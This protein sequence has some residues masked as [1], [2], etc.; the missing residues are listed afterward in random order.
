MSTNPTRGT[1]AKRLIVALA[2]GAIAASL[3]MGALAAASTA[4]AS[5][6]PHEQLGLTTVVAD[7]H[8]YLGPPVFLAQYAYPIFGG[9]TGAA[10]SGG[11]GSCYGDCI[12]T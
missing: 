8:E 12:S 5:A 3:S 7:P 2:G 6:D 1:T 10:S 4:G 11:I 9:S